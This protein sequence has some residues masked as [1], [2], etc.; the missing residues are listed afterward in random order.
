MEIPTIDNSA[1][2][3]IEIFEH[4]DGVFRATYCG[5]RVVFAREHPF[6]PE[7]ISMHPLNPKDTIPG[8]YG[9]GTQKEFRLPFNTGR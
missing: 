2:S 5:I 9:P 3:D 1:L 6:D 7:I 8:S 4:Y